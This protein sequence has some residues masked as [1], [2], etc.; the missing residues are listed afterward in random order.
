MDNNGS[1]R[2]A[3]PSSKAT[4]TGTHEQTTTRIPSIIIDNVI[5]KS[6]TP[7]IYF[8]HD[9]TTR[10][11]AHDREDKGAYTQKGMLYIYFRFVKAYT[12]TL[13]NIF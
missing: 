9:C 6:T 11:K 13:M 4:F 1:S 8:D 12:N 5:A 10:S 2:G 3:L 7:N